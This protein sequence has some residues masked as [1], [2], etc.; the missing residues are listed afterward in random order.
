MGSG[1]LPLKTRK[2]LY[3]QVILARVDL[4]VPSSRMGHG[5]YFISLCRVSK[6]LQWRD[7]VKTKKAS[8]EFIWWTPPA[9]PASG[10]SGQ[11]HKKSLSQTRAEIRPPPRR[12]P[13]K[14][15]KKRKSRYFWTRLR[16]PPNHPTS[17][18]LAGSTGGVKQY[19]TRCWSTWLRTGR[20]SLW[21]EVW[22]TIILH[23]KR[24]IPNVF[25]LKFS[26]IRCTSVSLVTITVMQRTKNGQEAPPWCLLTPEDGP[27]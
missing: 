13:N 24:W 26:K 9:S 23:R 22:V 1:H 16:T 7:M 12:S 27:F 21:A 25:F 18:T 14:P 8:W 5:A 6:V 15:L 3:I 20:R 19:F 2:W 17:P 4:K 11:A 10:H